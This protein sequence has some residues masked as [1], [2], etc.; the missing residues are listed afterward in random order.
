MSDSD[1]DLLDRVVKRLAAIRRRLGDRAF[2][3]A[4]QRALAGIGRAAL[5]EAERRASRQA[6]NS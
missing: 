6:P 5:T 3:D 2:R 1:R 4:V